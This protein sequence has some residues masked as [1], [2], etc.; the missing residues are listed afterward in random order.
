MTKMEV[1]IICGYG[2][3][4]L[5]IQAQRSGAFD[6]IRKP[7]D[8]R[9]LDLALQRTG[10]YHQARWHP[11]APSADRPDGAPKSAGLTGMTRSIIG[12]SAPIRR[13]K[14]MIHKV[15]ADRA[16]H[17][18]DHRRDRHRQGAGRPGDPPPQRPGP[19][20]VHPGQLHRPHPRPGR[21]RAVRAR[22]RRVHRG[23]RPQG[24]VL[25]AGRQGGT[26]FLDEIGDMDPSLQSRLLRVLESYCFFRV[27]GKMKISGRCAGG[28]RHQPRPATAGPRGR[29]PAG[30][31]PPPGG[32]HD[33]HSP[34]AG[35]HR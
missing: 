5:V 25:R 22:A 4:D 8:F 2:D 18:A 30:P 6:F 27:G 16:H 31:G 3:M 17:R 32:V 26:M 9:E 12:A 11:Q 7:M 19:P 1:I 21:E 23:A 34:L 15:A 24:R 29:F 20:A 28:G 13:L 35:H 33:P 14:T 10:K